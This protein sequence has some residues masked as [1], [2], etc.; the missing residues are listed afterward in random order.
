MLEDIWLRWVVMMAM[1]FSPQ[2]R[3]FRQAAAGSHEHQRDDVQDDRIMR[4]LVG[5]PL[6]I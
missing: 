4:D 5:R 3:V 6:K 1:D 2:P